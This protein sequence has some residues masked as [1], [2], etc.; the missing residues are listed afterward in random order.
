M[1]NKDFVETKIDNARNLAES[2]YNDIEN[3]KPHITQAFV[4]EKLAMVMSN[5]QLVSERLDLED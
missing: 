3:N 1:K 5:L 4:L 2:L